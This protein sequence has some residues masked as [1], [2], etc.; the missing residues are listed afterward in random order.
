MDKEQLVYQ[1]A[2]VQLLRDEYSAPLFSLQC[3]LVVKDKV[4]QIEG[5]LQLYLAGNFIDGESYEAANSSG[6]QFY[7]SQGY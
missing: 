2:Y 4:S 6:V 5:L 3:E 1:Q 7:H